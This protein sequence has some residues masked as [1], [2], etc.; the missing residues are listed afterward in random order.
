M[1]AKLPAGHSL[2]ERPARERD[3]RRCGRHSSGSHTAC[4]TSIRAARRVARAR[5]SQA[6]AADANEYDLLVQMSLA[7]LPA[8]LQAGSVSPLW[9]PCRGVRRQCNDRGLTSVYL[10][11]SSCAIETAFSISA[12]GSR[13][14]CLLRVRAD[15]SCANRSSWRIADHDALRGVPRFDP[16]VERRNRIEHERAVAAATMTHPGY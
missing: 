2:L 14:N 7:T 13:V 9:S 4:R 5:Q 15:R 1:P 8:I 10:A 3:S 16:F 11:R 12:A 6:A